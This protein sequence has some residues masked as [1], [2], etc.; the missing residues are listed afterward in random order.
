MTKQCAKWEMENRTTT[1][2]K[3]KVRRVRAWVLDDGFG[4]PKSRIIPKLIAGRFTT[5]KAAQD[6]IKKYLQHQG[7]TPQKI[8]IEWEE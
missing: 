3:K 7:F 2:P 5:K 4:L 8:T 1:K 6:Y